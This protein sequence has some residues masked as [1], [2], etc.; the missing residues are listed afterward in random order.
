MYSTCLFCNRSLGRNEAIEAFR[1]LATDW[2]L[3][4]YAQQAWRRLEELT[5]RRRLTG[6]ESDELVDRYQRVATHLSVVRTS[7]RGMP[8]A[9]SSATPRTTT[10]STR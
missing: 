2:P 8:A 6:P 9:C 5:A 10:C 7:A 4:Y 1:Q 3:A